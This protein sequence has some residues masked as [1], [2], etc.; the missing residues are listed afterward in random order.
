[1]TAHRIVALI[2]DAEAA[3][4]RVDIVVGA[5][6]EVGSRAEAQRLNLGLGVVM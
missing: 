2:A 4:R 6:P 3:G 5:I 1:M